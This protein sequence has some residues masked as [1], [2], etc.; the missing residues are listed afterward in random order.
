MNKKLQSTNFYQNIFNLVE[1]FEVWSI[2]PWRRYSFF[3]II[4]LLGFVLGGSLGMVCGALALMDP[5]G[6]LFTVIFIELIIRLRIVIKR[7][8]KKSN[9]LR[10]V[11]M[12]RIGIIYGLITEALKLL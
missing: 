11:D 10:V 4:V 6:A 3:L 1:K 12:F 2:N 8:N 7:M 5:L 9:L